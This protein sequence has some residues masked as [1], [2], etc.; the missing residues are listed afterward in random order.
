M[1]DMPESWASV[2]ISDVISLNPKTDAPDSAE[3]G[4]SPMSMLGVT[5]LSRPG[6]EARPW[7]AIKKSYTH[8]ADGDVLLAK[9]TPCFENGKAGLA[10]GLPNGIGAGSSEYFVCRPNTDVLEGRYLLAFLKTDAFVRGGETQ[11]TGS[12]GQ[13]RLPKDYLL[14]TQLPLAPLAEQKRIADKLDA[15]LARVDACRTRLDRLPALLKRFR[16]SVL[17][18]AVAG[19]LTAEWRN[20]QEQQ[21]ECLLS[22]DPNLDDLPQG[23]LNLIA[24]RGWRIVRAKDAVAPEAD[25]VYG[26]VQPGPKL[27]SGVPYVQIT[28]IADGRIQVQS[29]SRTDEE[30]AKSYGRSSIRGGDVLLGIIRAIKV[31]VVP[32]Q[33]EGANISRS[34]ARLRPRE[35][36]LPS[37]LAIALESPVIQGWLR[38]QHRGMDMPVLNLSE[39]RL[40]PIPIAPPTEQA[41]IVRRVES[42]LALADSLQAKVQSARGQ[43]ERL[44]PALLAKAFRGELVP[45]EPN[46][47]PADALLARLRDDAAQ[48]PGVDLAPKKLDR[49]AASARRSARPSV[50]MP[51]D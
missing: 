40:A 29:L 28:D 14:G 36:L 41:E 38:S 42:L 48:R 6:F 10:Q 2:A 18:A 45:Q 17:S 15:L 44:T 11:M 4:F 37:F 19:Q 23:D 30:I 21:G 46:D 7:G 27:A 51:A 33:L 22:I 3:A 13:K 12:V 34:V 1:K 25:I 24:P 32:D 35:G 31:A 43:L 47:E 5:Y 39:V 20:A 8:F 9:I 16:Q 26:I 49:R 50:A